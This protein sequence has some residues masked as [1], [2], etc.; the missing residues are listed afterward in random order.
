MKEIEVQLQNG[1]KHFLRKEEFKFFL[2]KNVFVTRKQFL[3]CLCYDITIHKSQGLSLENAV[4]D[5]GDSIFQCGQTYVALSRVTEL[6]G[7]HLINL[8]PSKIK[9]NTLALKEYN[10]SRKNFR[11][12]LN[13]LRE[14]PEPTRINF[15][16]NVWATPESILEIQESI[17][18]MPDGYK[19]H[20]LVNVNSVSSYA[21]CLIKCLFYFKNLRNQFKIIRND[22]LKN[23]YDLYISKNI[24]N[25]L[26][27]KKSVDQKFEI[28]IEQDVANFFKLLSK[29]S[30]IV[31]NTIKFKVSK[32]IKCRIPIRIF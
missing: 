15:I 26:E 17:Q 32:I 11:P 20:R 4:I 23:I 24:I 30:T 1:A 12:N 29:K 9:A 25:L 21:H 3:I 18:N 7:L 6:E 2:K 27:F 10:R 16:E 13:Q 22:F 14:N 8:N 31:H 19:L 28:D 5:A